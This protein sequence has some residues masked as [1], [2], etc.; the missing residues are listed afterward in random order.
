MADRDRRRSRDR[1]GGRKGSEPRRK[2]ASRPREGADRSRRGRSRS[3]RA[4]PPVEAEMYR[5]TKID[6][7]DGFE[8]AERLHFH[9]HEDDLKHYAAKGMKPGYTGFGPKAGWCWWWQT[10]LAIPHGGQGGC[11]GRPTEPVTV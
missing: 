7:D 9:I 2:S 10:W 5:M 11:G 1:H 6:L 3:R 4:D 8:A